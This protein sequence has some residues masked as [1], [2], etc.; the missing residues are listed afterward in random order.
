MNNGIALLIFSGFIVS[1]AH[2]LMKLEA[3]KRIHDSATHFLSIKI[4]IAYALMFIGLLLS[5]IAYRQV[6]LKIGPV[7]ETLNYVYV[8]GLSWVLLKEKFG[9]K[10]FI[11]ILL[12]ICGVFISL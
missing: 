3:L 4:M 2:L 9:W 5:F 1:I 10:T 6:S 12:I 7:I 11:G 8:L